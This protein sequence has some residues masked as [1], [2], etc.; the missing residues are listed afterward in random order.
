MGLGGLSCKGVGKY[1]GEGVEKV[2]R[3]SM[4][5]RLKVWGR[6]VSGEGIVK[7]KGL[8]SEEI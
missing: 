2:V 5:S 4:F 8:R 3:E 6:V 1:G 7:V